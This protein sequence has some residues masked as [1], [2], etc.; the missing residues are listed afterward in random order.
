MAFG[1]DSFAETPFSALSQVNIDVG[2]I[3]QQLTANLSN[4]QIVSSVELTGLE[5]NLTLNSASIETIDPG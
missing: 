5:A 1:F 2:V 4:V 3:G